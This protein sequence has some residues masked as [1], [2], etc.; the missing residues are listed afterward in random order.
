MTFTIQLKGFD[1]L[2]KKLD[3]L[4]RGKINEGA[5]KGIEKAAPVVEAKLKRNTPVDT[6]DLQDS[7]RIEITTGQAAIG[8]DETKLPHY[9][10]DVEFGHHTRS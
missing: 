3:N 2:A 10:P 1:A 8:P 4:A 7:T 5:Q 6:G 9:A